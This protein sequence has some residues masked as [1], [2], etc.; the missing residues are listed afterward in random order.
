MAAI[1]CGEQWLLDYADGALAAEVL[2]LAER[3]LSACP[4]CRQELASL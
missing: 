3:H 4:R 2:P 1:R